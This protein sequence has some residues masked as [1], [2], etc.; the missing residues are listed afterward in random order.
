MLPYQVH[1]PFKGLRSES[2]VKGT[3]ENNILPS[4]GVINLPS[5]Q[6][7]HFLYKKKDRQ[8]CVSVQ[9]CW[10]LRKTMTAL[11]EGRLGSRKPFGSVGLKGLN[12][13]WEGGLRLRQVGTETR[14]DSPSMPEEG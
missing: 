12:S 4:K 6:I 11:P 8:H 7:S 13:R 1:V 5:R 9:T 3:K 14:P 10:S 2:C